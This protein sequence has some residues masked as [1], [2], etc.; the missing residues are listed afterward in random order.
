MNSPH[1]DSMNELHDVSVLDSIDRIVNDKLVDSRPFHNPPVVDVFIRVAGDLL[2]VG[3][4]T[5]VR[6]PVEAIVAMI[7]SWFLSHYDSNYD[8]PDFLVISE[9]RSNFGRSLLWA[10]EASA[11]SP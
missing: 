8:S 9:F 11:A 4:A 5:T 1:R 2:L 10:I 7:P 6:V 3:R